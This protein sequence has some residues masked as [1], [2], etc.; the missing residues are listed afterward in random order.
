MERQSNFR[1]WKVALILIGGGLVATTFRL[2]QEPDIGDPTTNV[3]WATKS[4]DLPAIAVSEAVSASDSQLR[5]DAKVIGVSI[6]DWYRAYPTDALSRARTHVIN[7]FVN[8]RA[9]SVAYCD[10]TDCARLF[11]ASGRSGPLDIAVGGWFNEDGETDMLVR[12]G[13]NRYRMKSGIPFNPA[14]SPFPYESVEIETT[15]WH[16]WFTAHPTTD[17]FLVAIPVDLLN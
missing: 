17:V 3:K 1:W 2:G 10:R 14:A 12:V 7:D 4:V 16:E 13:S 6:D 11:S 5:P 9:F 8:G 15:T